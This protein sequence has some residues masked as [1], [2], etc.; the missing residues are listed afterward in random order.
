MI[1]SSQERC[2]GIATRKRQEKE[3]AGKNKSEKEI[4]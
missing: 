2:L 1:A 4:E 3:A